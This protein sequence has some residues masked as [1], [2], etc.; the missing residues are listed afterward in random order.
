M[1]VRGM[2]RDG[3][4]RRRMQ[5][6]FCATLAGYIGLVGRLLYLQGVVGPELRDKAER[7][8]EQPI[9]LRAFRGSIYDR[10]GNPLAISRY[11]GTLSFDPVVVEQ[12]VRKGAKTADV[13]E[14]RLKTGITRLAALLHMPEADIANL[15]SEARRRYNPRRPQRFHL[16]KNDISL[17]VAQQ[18][19][20]NR[21]LLPGFGIIDGSKRVY[22]GGDRAAQAVGFVGPRWHENNKKEKEA[23][24]K[25]NRPVPLPDEVGKAGMEA[26]CETYLR[27]T[28]GYAIAEVDYR[29]REIPDTLKRMEPAEDGLD[30]ISTLDGNAQHIATDEARRVFEK[31][32]PLGVTVCIIEPK[33]GD[34]LALVSMPNYD[35]NPDKR[36]SLTGEALAER[37][38]ARLYEPGSTLKALTVAAA[39]DEGIIHLGDGFYC[40][41]ALQT[42][43]RILHCDSHGGARHGHGYVTPQDIIRRSCNVGSARIGL[44]MTGQRLYDADSKFGLFSKFGIGIPAEQPGY[45]SLDRKNR[46]NIYSSAKVARVAFGHAVTTTPLHVALAYAT[47]ANGGNLMQPRLIAGLRDSKGKIKQEWKPKVLRRVISEQTS[48]EMSAMLRSVVSAGTGKGASVP[49]YRV[50][51]KTGTAKKYR[52][53]AYVGSF[54]GY[55]PA[56]PN[57]TPRAVILV[58]VDEPKGAFYGGDVAAPAFQSIA[59]RLMDYWN[60]PEDD[61]EST[62]Y[63]EA[64][65]IKKSAPVKNVASRDSARRLR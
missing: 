15:V 52:A 34:I 7:M 62:Q 6:A 50:A 19:R 40:N 51:G 4:L 55:L 32:H 65:K 36:H 30:V 53:G 44:K 60:V 17:D 2:P 22:P 16:V 29:R 3:M 28:P 48:H 54:V 12:E 42:G 41:G 38:T 18:I 25:K 35:P 45:L 27:G 24:E 10:D 21:T 8:R 43:K 59:K 64:H 31:Y 1:A 33:S 47:F 37:N 23:E 39:L 61:P 13:T 11:S 26:F 20:E 46:E 58:T 56:S 63:N 14:E 9:P 57:V 49:G 5:V